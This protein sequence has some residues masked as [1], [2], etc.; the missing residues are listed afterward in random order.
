MFLGPNSRITGGVASRRAFP[1]GTQLPF[2]Q[3]VAP[4]GWARISTYDDSAL[5]IMATATPGSGGTNG[6]STVMAQTTVGNTTLTT[7]QIPGH[8]HNHDYTNAASGTGAFGVTSPGAGSI[9]TP[10]Q[11]ETGV[12]GVGGG[13]GAH[14]HSIAM[15]MKYVDA[16]IARKT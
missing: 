10:G 6:F 16:L 3:A 12:N 2:V 8:Y 4:V 7:A 11:T 15:S 13:G 5:R 1:A 9:S 14:N